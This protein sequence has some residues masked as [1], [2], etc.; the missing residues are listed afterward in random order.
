MHL[1]CLHLEVVNEQTEQQAVICSWFLFTIIYLPHTHTREMAL[2]IWH[3]GDPK[4]NFNWEKN[5]QSIHFAFLRGVDKYIIIHAHGHQPQKEKLAFKKVAGSSAAKWRLVWF[6][7]ASFQSGKSLFFWEFQSFPWLRTLPHA[8]FSFCG[9]IMGDPMKFATFWKNICPFLN[10]NVMGW[11]PLKKI[12]LSIVP[13]NK[14]KIR[15]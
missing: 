12:T 8:D 4:K 10:N 11:M 1:Q 3:W 9:N 5:W 7:Y 14:T 2:N 13:E 6:G 15:L